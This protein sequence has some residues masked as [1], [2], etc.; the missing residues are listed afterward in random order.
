MSQVSVEFF[1]GQ[2]ICLV[3][4][5]CVDK[6]ANILFSVLVLTINCPFVAHELQLLGNEWSYT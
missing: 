2:I 4:Y 5:I 3:S 1:S 6:P